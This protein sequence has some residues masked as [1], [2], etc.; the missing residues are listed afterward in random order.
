MRYRVTAGGPAIAAVLVI[1]GIGLPGVITAAIA[2]F[3]VKQM[4]AASVGPEPAQ[5]TGAVLSM[6]GTGAFVIEIDGLLHL[7][8]R[9]SE[10]T[11][12][13]EPESAS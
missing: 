3:F 11:S 7:A 13:R 9:L 4:Q 12:S 5:P 10:D 1:C 8:N 6:T 2:A